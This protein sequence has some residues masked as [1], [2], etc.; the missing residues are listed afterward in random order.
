VA[1]TWK[2]LPAL[3][4][5][6]LIFEGLT[7][8]DERGVVVPRLAKSWDVSDDG[9]TYMFEL[10][11]DVVWHDGAPFTADGVLFTVGV[12]SDPDFLALDS[13]GLFDLWSS[14]TAEKLDDYTVQFVLSEPFAPFLDY[15]TMGILPAHLLSKIEARLLPK[16]QFNSQPIGTGPF[17]V[18]SVTAK[19]VAL[20]ANHAYYGDKPIMES[21]VFRFYPDT[22]SLFAAYAKGEINAISQVVPSL[23]SRVGAEHSL[24]LYS[25]RLSKYTMILFNLTD[26][27]LPFFQQAEVR[28][29]LL[30]GLDREAIVNRV[31]GGQGVVA[32]SPLIPDTWAYNSNVF[33]YDHD[34][35]KAK[36]L[37]DQAGWTDLDGDGIR[38]K[39]GRRLE[40]SLTT[41]GDPTWSRVVQELTRQWEEL[42][43]L[44]VPETVS[45]PRLV[46]EFLYPRRFEAILI[47]PEF[48]G[49]PDPY[50]F[51]H[52][53]QIDQ[54]GQNWSGFAHRRADE[55]MEEAR[56]TT[57]Q[58][59]RMQL[60]HEFQD[61]FA[62]QVPAI[63]LYY[64]VYNYAIDAKVQNV[65]VAP[66]NDS[67]D[68]F[69][70]ITKWYIETKRFA[71]GVN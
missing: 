24:N 53:T 13:S 41:S 66:M 44:V 59:R 42:G 62:E 28:R 12:M 2:E 19:R 67:S 33:T 17:K 5:C 48:A 70:T 65:Q 60:Y 7:D 38:E 30:W 39:D 9:L 64:P 27:E 52:S 63:L 45:F 56:V 23:V 25:A 31:L 57:D 1:H 58:A 55:I 61:I 15:T 69:R 37:L 26:E 21:L 43:V 32:H 6:S 16:A 68:R 18:E 51:W 4:L 47:A 35:P 11:E 54:G 40:F 34:L 3:D 29:A 10:R 71:F 49:D 36:E 8:F 14:V 22:E 50:P 46:G 20:T